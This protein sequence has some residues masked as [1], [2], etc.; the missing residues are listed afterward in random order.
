MIEVRLPVMRCLRCSRVMGNPE[1]LCLLRM[2][3][4]KCNAQRTVDRFTIDPYNATSMVYPCNA[5]GAAPGDHVRYF[6]K[7]GKAIKQ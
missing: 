1:C 7:D 6:D 5:C 2:T 3:C 4:P